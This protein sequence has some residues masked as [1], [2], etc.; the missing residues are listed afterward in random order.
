MDEFN[1]YGIRE[2]A[3]VCIYELDEND[4]IIKPFIYLD[5]LKCSTID[6]A[7]NITKIQGGKG[8]S[9]LSTWEFLDKLEITLQDALFSMKSLAMITGGQLKES[10]D[11]I[12]K[13][14][15]F[16]ATAKTLP[17]EGERISGWEPIFSFYNYST[18]KLNPVFYN[19]YGEQITTLNEGEK[20]F[21]TYYLASHNISIDIKDT[22]FPGY[23]CL[24]GET[25]IRNS[26]TNEDELFYFVVPKAKLKSDF[27]LNIGSDD[28]TVI[29]LFFTAVK[30]QQ[31]LDLIEFLS[32]KDLIV[33]SEEDLEKFAILGKAV[34][35]K[36]ILGKKREA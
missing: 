7:L 2:V 8:N 34:L 10:E 15:T 25:F 27:A 26:I 13:T 14:E 28:S 12:I 4:N 1:L 3:D 11:L 23:Y 31:N 16:I 30:S 32:V 35:G 20:Y 19:I 21:C 24:V 6:Y 9:L 36:L 29:D 33:D 22:D 5:T 18:L 17:K